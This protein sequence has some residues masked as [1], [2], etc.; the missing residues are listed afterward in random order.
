MMLQE[1][2]TRCSSLT[3]FP[4][5]KTPELCAAGAMSVRLEIGVPTIDADRCIAC[6][7][8]AARCPVGAIYLDLTGGA[9]VSVTPSPAFIEAP[10]DQQPAFKATID[11]LSAIDHTGVFAKESDA[12]VG[13]TLDKMKLARIST[14]DRF[15]VLHARNLMVAL[16]QGAAMRRKGNNHM[17]MDLLLGPPGVVK[18][19]VEVE[20]GQNAVLDAPRD[21]LDALAVLTS[22]Y[23]WPM[24]EVAPIIITDELPNKR[25][26]YWDIVKDIR[27]VIGIHIGTITTLALHLL[28]WSRVTIPSLRLFHVDKD[29]GSYRS[30]V[31]E[32]LVGRPLSLSSKPKSWI[33]IA[34]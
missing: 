9:K 20:F 17:R 5:D 1:Y 29:S 11:K 25:S 19:V 10:A 22:R 16:G 15:P 23:K 13:R 34:K 14:G 33:E 7:I 32:K 30:V 8:C 18:G 26:E 6:G 28:I 4:A 2:E 21:L 3:A 31:L 24:K 27:E 12:M